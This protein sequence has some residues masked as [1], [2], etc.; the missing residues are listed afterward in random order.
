MEILNASQFKKLD[1]D[2]RNSQER[3]VQQILGKIKNNLSESEYKKLYP[4]GSRP[5]LFY[6]TPKVHKQKR[7]E[8]LD[9]LTMRPI[10]SNIGTA[11][12][13]TAKYL[14]KL[15]TPLANSDYN[16]L[17]IEDLISRLRNEV[18]PD[19]YKMTSFDVKSLFTIMPLDRAKYIII[20]KVYE[21]RKIKA[22]ILKTVLK[23]LLC[24]CTKYLHFT[25]N[26]EIYIQINYVAMGSSLGP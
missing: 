21:E 19:G 2:P 4:A 17:N 14:N 23:E 20:K 3:K 26:D 12:N 11:T 22:N 15:L 9:K 13:E 7:Q 18:I 16:I 5:G 1:I 24:L 6:S 10:I 8:G 25:F